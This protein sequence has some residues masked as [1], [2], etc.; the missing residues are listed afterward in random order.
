M[1]RAS[2]CRVHTW[3]AGML[4][5]EVQQHIARVRSLP[6]VEQIALFPDAHLAGDACVGTAILSTS[7]LVPAWLGSD[8][9]C[10]V[11]GLPIGAREVPDETRWV[12]ALHALQ[13]VVPIHRHPAARHRPEV[14]ASDTFHA[15]ASRASH[16]WATLGR[17]NHFVELRRCAAS[18]EHWLLV[19][20]GS[21]SLGPSVQAHYEGLATKR[22]GGWSH[23][24]AQ[25]DD[26]ANY[27]RDVA[28]CVAWA[29]GSRRAMLH[30]CVEALAEVFEVAPDWPALIDTH[31]DSLML[32]EGGYLH[33]K[34]AM[35]LAQDALGI[36]PGSMGD[37]VYVVRSRGHRDALAS[38]AHGAGRA[39]P[40]AQCRRRFSGHDLA[41][42]MQGIVLDR[43]AREALL[44]ELPEA[45]KDID[46]VMRA[47]RDV[48]RVVSRLDACVV[49]KGT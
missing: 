46:S 11:A 40:R 30:A 6:H 41:R 27:L 15:L 43:R 47:Q 31:H 16:E 4:D 49:H 35:C 37:A 13:R 20:T 25:S 9:G 34:G 23:L 5:D 8:L 2:P 1:K 44:E 42:S 12:Q 32:H 29:E 17:G 36:I 24:D 22:L 19:H 18:S 21:R 7:K 10:G 3:H 33:R 48:V 38:A 14:D 26:G 39:V 28:A 45:Y